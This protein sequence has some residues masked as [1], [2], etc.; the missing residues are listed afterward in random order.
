MYKKIILNLT[1]LILTFAAPYFYLSNVEDS[2]EPELI[3]VLAFVV[4]L[5]GSILLICLNSTY[6]NKVPKSKWIWIPLIVIGV[7]GVIYSG[8]ILYLFYAFRGGIGF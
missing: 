2:I 8:S 7:I 5:L 1:I 3:N 6:I 4:I